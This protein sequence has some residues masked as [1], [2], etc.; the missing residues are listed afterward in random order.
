MKAVGL[1]AG[2]HAKVVL[3]ALAADSSIEV[4]GLVDANPQMTGRAVSGVAVLGGDD[5]L[6]S[7]QRNGVE[8][9][10]MCVGSRAETTARQRLYERAVGCGLR[11]LSVIHR[12]ALISPSAVMGAGAVVLAGAIVGVEAVLGENVLINTGAIVDHD[13]RLGDHVHVATGARLA[14]A[15]TIERGAHIGV[16]ATIRQGLRIGANSVVGAGAVVVDDVPAHVVVA[17]VPA[18]LLRR[19]A[20]E[21]SAS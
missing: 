3:E 9:F 11:P 6:P 1:G 12:H 16:G 15:V 17:G 5:L 19:A 7:L 18:T 14:G 8:C 4:V 13:V 10:V 21:T 2:G 20:G